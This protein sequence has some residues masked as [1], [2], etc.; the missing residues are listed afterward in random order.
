MRSSCSYDCVLVMRPKHQ[1][2]LW[3]GVCAKVSYRLCT[4][5]GWLE[6]MT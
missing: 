5:G 6:V 4:L 1:K 3:D 2:S